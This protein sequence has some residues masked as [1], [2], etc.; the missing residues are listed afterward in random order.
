VN[1]SVFFILTRGSSEEKDVLLSSLRNLEGV[2]YAGF[3]DR[4]NKNAIR[5]DL[6][7]RTDF[8]VSIR[9]EE[10][11]AVE[12]IVTT[13]LNDWYGRAPAEEVAKL[14]E[15]VFICVGPVKSGRTP[16]HVV[17]EILPSTPLLPFTAKPAELCRRIVR[18]DG[19]K[20]EYV[21]RGRFIVLYRCWGRKARASETGISAVAILSK[22][23]DVEGLCYVINLLVDK[24][25]A[26][27]SYNVAEVGEV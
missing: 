3:V 16:Q 26:N 1:G 23:V 11:G 12:R 8:N 13:Y 5:L 9:L 4:V 6:S 22:D 24:L 15:R 14:I 25:V 19:E 17:V 27:R 18:W 20:G 10:P 2:R 21:E 7:R